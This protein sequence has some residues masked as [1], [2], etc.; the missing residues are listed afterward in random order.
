[1]IERR[2]WLA[3]RD[4]ARSSACDCMYSQ[5]LRARSGAG[6]HLPRRD[7]ARPGNRQVAATPKRPACSS[8]WRRPPARPPRAASV[9]QPRAVGELHAG[10]HQRTAHARSYD[11]E[12]HAEQSL[13]CRGTRGTTNGEAVSGEAVSPNAPTQHRALCVRR[14]ARHAA[15]S[16]TRSSNEA[17]MEIHPATAC[18][19]RP[20]A[21][22]SALASPVSLLA[23]LALALPPFSAPSPPTP[24]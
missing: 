21:P 3:G 5:G 24:T 10:L 22:P 2:D 4:V 13:R 17:C 11:E 18:G 16:A 7:R 9:V 19:A 1:M 20:G 12:R 15:P 8:A 23:S 6:H 14:S